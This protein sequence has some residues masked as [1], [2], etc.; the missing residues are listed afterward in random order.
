MAK[1]IKPED[2][3]KYLKKLQ[4][5]KSDVA[6]AKELD[7]SRPSLRAIKAGKHQPKA[8]LISKLGLEMLYRT[9]K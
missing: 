3:G 7:I 5:D 6:Y 2:L 8:T 9:V 1:T 4:G